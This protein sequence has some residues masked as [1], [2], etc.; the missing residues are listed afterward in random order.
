MGTGYS[1]RKPT[2]LSYSRST[3]ITAV[4]SIFASLSSR[5]DYGPYAPVA[6]GRGPFLVSGSLS[7]S[8]CPRRHVIAAR[9]SY[10]GF[11]S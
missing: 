8:F 6:A 9:L 2:A 4:A 10:P 3:A 5:L 11:A 1:L 7:R